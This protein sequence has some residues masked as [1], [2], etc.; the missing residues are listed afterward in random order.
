HIAAP[1][2]PLT[3]P[4]APQ[5]SARPGH[6]LQRVAPGQVGS[7]PLPGSV[8]QIP[9]LTNQAANAFALSGARRF[10]SG[11]I[12]HNPLFVNRPALAHT[13][14]R[15]RLAQFSARHHQHFLPI[16]AVGFIGPLFWPYDAF[17][18]VR[19]MTSM[20]ASLMS[21]DPELLPVTL[22]QELALL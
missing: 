8:R 19:M 21:T 5:L 12:L 7:A 9:R 15:G 4:V 17:W 13:I 16:I 14:F 11:Q 10:G 1:R 3:S 6:L 2:A 20:T 22:D 18:R